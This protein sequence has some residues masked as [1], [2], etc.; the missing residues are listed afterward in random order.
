MS[1][2]RLLPPQ[3]INQIAAGEVVER[4]AS[5]VK[6]LVENSLDAGAD[7]IEVTVEAGG[8]QRIRVRDNGT[9]M[10]KDELPLSVAR[11]ATSK[12]ATVEDLLQVKTL[13]FRGEALPSIASVASLELVSRNGDQPCG[14]RVVVRPSGE[15]DAPVAVAH[16]QGTTVTVTDLFHTIPARRKFLRA[17]RT[18]FGHIRQYLE[19]L[20]LSRFDVGFL[21]T[22]NRREIFQ[23][24]AISAKEQWDERVAVILGREFMDQS[25]KIEFSTE[26]MRLWG[27]IG[28]PAI[29]RR[30]ADRQYWFINGRT[31]R[32][33]L[34]TFALRSAYRD[35]L[36]GD[37][38]P[39][40]LLYLE[41]NPRLVDVN[42]HPAKLEVR[43]RDARMVRDFIS[44]SLY[45]A[46]AK[47]RPQA[48]MSKPLTKSVVAPTASACMKVGA[49]VI[50][51]S[52]AFYE[53]LH[54]SEPLAQ[55]AFEAPVRVEQE[56][57]EMPVVP[58]LGYAVAHLHGIYILAEAENGL[59]IVDAHAAHERIIY[60]KLKRQ[61]EMGEVIRQPL[62]LPLRIQASAH[63]VDLVTRHRESLL[64]V[65]LELDAIGPEALVIRAL[66]T[67]L[68]QADAEM[69]VRDV[70][71]EL[72]QCECASEIQVAIRERLASCACH[73]AVRAGQ[74]LTRDEMN[75][76]LRELEQTDR[77]NQCNHGR[78]TW[79]TLDFQALDNFFHRGR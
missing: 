42:A 78:P 70:I 8:I 7:Q 63:E 19:R 44:Q 46:L 55:K 36:P 68:A 54:A 67:L 26:E 9:G 76:L 14:W 62:L 16:P 35:V 69:L 73:R 59:V 27:W 43:F 32:D 74:R 33:K 75:A 34:L 65:G 6:E 20:A 61:I 47:S 29:A 31:V 51:E 52:L 22:H 58:P 60:E 64:Q 40:A 39:A 48:D 11:H 5:V 71:A 38:Q 30:Q 56:G 24:Q 21:L 10:A 37:R 25:L 66:P 4:P 1:R 23:F 50:N 45:R 17:E 12:I 2:I 53:S 15:V 3:L 77:G 18:E 72:D 79:V 57:K 28:L 41:I 49:D 13:G